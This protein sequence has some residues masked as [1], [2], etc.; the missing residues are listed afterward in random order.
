MAEPLPP[1]TL[2]KSRLKKLGNDPEAAA[3]AVHLVYVNCSDDG[4]CRIKEGENFI[5]KYRGKLVKNKTLL[6]RIELLVLPP[7]WEDVWI[8]PL[9]NGHLQATGKDVKNRKQ[10]RYHPLWNQLRSKTKFYRMLE[11]G[12][13]LPTIRK[14]LKKDLA[15]PGLPLNKVLALVIS[16]MEKTGIRIGNEFYEK[17]YGSF[18]LT[19]L[20]DRH[21]KIKGNTVK[22]TFRGKKGV[23]HQVSLQ[24][25]KLSKIVMQC[26]DIPGKE[27][28]QYID[29]EGKRQSIESGMINDY[30]KA[31]AEGEFTTKDFRTWCGS[32]AALN[33]FKETGSF[34]NEKEAKKKIV[35]V[36]DKVS[37]QL[38]NSRTVCK[39]YYVHPSLLEMYENGKMEKLLEKMEDCKK[40]DDCDLEAEEKIFMNMLES[41]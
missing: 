32:V 38:G 39:K 13:V 5:Y 6:R 25:K 21:V 24:S 27:L 7:A 35:E 12:K 14:Q 41:L 29:E 23:E 36:L 18:G 19:T 15:L 2:K 33:A 37:M 3:K 8:C 17:L 34:E 4:I 9:P 30:I 16:L 28:F 10:Y 20:K 11:L 1:I 31:I 26:R 40:N 22:F